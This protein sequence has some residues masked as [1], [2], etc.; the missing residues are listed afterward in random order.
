M[1]PPFDSLLD[2]NEIWIQGILPL[3][4]VGEYAFVGAVNKKMNQLYKE[5]CKTEL[6]KNPSNVEDN[7]D[8]DSRSAEIT[9]TLYSK[10]FCNQPR[11]EYWLKDISN[12]KAPGHAHVCTAIAKIGNITVMRWARQKGFPWNEQTC[13]RAAEYGHLEM[14]QWSRENGCPWNERTCAEAAEG[15]HLDVLKWARENRCRWDSCTCSCAAEGGH[16]D[17][18]KWAREM[19]VHGSIDMCLC[20]FKWHLDLKWARENGCP[21][22]VWTCAFAARNGHLEI[23]KWA[24]K[25]FSMECKDMCRCCRMW[26]FG[27][28][29]A[30]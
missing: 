2:K 4:G 1:S 23:L 12:P 17:T 14:L 30:P 8:D 21:W 7:P 6:D 25:W 16:L 24:V 26:P 22:D 28:L 9:D 18:L 10:T 3:V 29:S 11:A 15:G 13:A 19:G 27:N 5:Y 20:C